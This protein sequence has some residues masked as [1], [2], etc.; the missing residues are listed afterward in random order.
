M[1]DMRDIDPNST[2]PDHYF[3]KALQ[4]PEFKPQSLSTR[5]T[6][7]LSSESSFRSKM[8]KSPSGCR[9]YIVDDQR[10]SVTSSYPH[11]NYLISDTS[12]C[13]THND[14]DSVCSSLAY[15]EES[16]AADQYLEGEYREDSN[17]EVD[18]L[19]TTIEKDG[20]EHQVCF[21][22]FGPLSWAVSLL[23]DSFKK[24]SLFP[25]DS[26]LQ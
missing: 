4:Y 19:L 3:D 6:L 5:K 13:T 12:T 2:G 21:P 15:S 14:L 25:D 7:F 8:V 18:L 1:R 17:I 24:P 11:S 16:W 20:R 26:L 10:D 23:Q 22:C 9:I